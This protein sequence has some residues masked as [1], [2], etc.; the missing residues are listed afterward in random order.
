MNSETIAPKEMKRRLD[1]GARV[2][3]VRTPVEFASSHVPGALNVP[4]DR[5]DPAELKGSGVAG[6]GGPLH[7]ICRSGARA[8]K[9]AEKARAAG[10]EV[11]CIEGGMDAWEAAGLPAVRGRKSVSLERQVRIA[12]GSLV[13]TGVAL[14]F[15]VHPAFFGLAGFVGAGL[16]FAGVTDTCAMGMLIA[17]APWNRVAGGSPAGTGGAGASGA[18]TSGGSDGGSCCTR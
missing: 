2:V 13:V 9:A 18:G 6:P 5:F 16:V 11:V 3:D 4:L 10:L 1:E 14:G 15:L 7:L 12:A 17:R 8:S